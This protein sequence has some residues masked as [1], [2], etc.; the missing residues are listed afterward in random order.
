MSGRLTERPTVLL[1]DDHPLILEGLKKLLEP[2]FEMVGT[3]TNGRALLKA[4]EKLKPDLI[5]ADLSMPGIDGVEAT[6]RLRAT[7]PDSRVL[8]LSIHTEPSWVRAAFD[9]GAC[10]YLTKVSAGEEI[11]RAVHEILEDR[12]YVSPAVARAAVTPVGE[13]L[14]DDRGETSGAKPLAAGDELTEREREV[15]VLVGQGLG[16][17]AIARRLGISVTT[18]RTHLKKIYGKLELTTRVELALHAR[19][20]GPAA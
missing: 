13:D 9:A 3:V 6:R 14:Q 19:Q 1:A 11:R 5:L 4:A 15:A 18:V 2:D 16:N 20:V 17:H 7:V 10:G 12:F 8:I